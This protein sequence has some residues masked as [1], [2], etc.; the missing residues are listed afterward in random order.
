AYHPVGFSFQQQIHRIG[1]HHRRVYTVT[2]GRASA[3]LHVTQ[4]RGSGLDSRSSL[5]SLG[6]AAGMSDSLGVDNDVML[7]SAFSVV[8]DIVDDL[9]LIV[10]ILLRQENI[11]RAIGYTAPESDISGISSHNFDDTA[12]LMGGGGVT[13]LVDG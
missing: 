8:N 4:D 11:L 6:H 2:A 12:P 9:L 7:L 10:I 3:S 5:D 13:Y 1:A